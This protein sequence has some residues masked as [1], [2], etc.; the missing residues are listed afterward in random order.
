MGCHLDIHIPSGDSNRTHSLVAHSRYTGH[1]EITKEQLDDIVASGD[2]EALVGASE[3][4]WLECKGQPYQI[5]NDDARRE[6]AKDVSSFANASGGRLI[7]G[8][9][10]KSSSTHFGDEIA[11]VRSFAQ[12]LVN[13]SQY[14]AVL[15]AWVYPAIPGVTVIWVPTKN[16]PVDGV[17]VIT[18]PPQSTSSKPYLVTRTS[19]GT[20]YSETLLGYAERKGDKSKPLS[21]AELQA[22]LRAGLNYDA[23]VSSKF[24]A[25][26]TLIKS[27]A[28]ATPPP[29][30]KKIPEETVKQRIQ[31]AVSHGSIKNGRYIVIAA[32][33][34][35]E[36]Q[37]KTIF[38]SSAGSIRR[39]LEN[40][41]QLRSY[42]WDLTHHDQA[43]IMK[44]EAIRVTNGDSKVVD[45][46][47]D[48]TMIAAAPADGTFLA[49]G[50]DDSKQRL[51]PLALIEYI[52]SFLNFYS[53]V[54]KDFEMPPTTV[55]LRIELHHMYLENIN[56]TLGPY[57]LQSTSQQFAMH[58]QP[59]PADDG[60]FDLTVSAD[61]F[62]PLRL[63]FDVVRE[64]YL[65]FGIEEDKIPYFKMEDGV[66][67][68]DVDALSKV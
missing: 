49:W 33:P 14:A 29:P 15:D 52:Y 42:G 37:L 57:G 36:G 55:A 2:F 32:V 5:A 63:A 13:T 66:R 62:K 19:V 9:Q 3:T 11:K 43:K 59:A 1:V 17:V 24:E 39:Q 48:G 61:D 23:L 64:V 7:I 28:T 22:A 12:T 41:P 60:V 20:K 35:P 18:I 34:T 68:L 40:P 56:S 25:L 8:L 45:L 4:A 6:L 54:L 67:Q 58:E 53:L 44:R 16:D 26:E 65:W 31:T 38:S 47:R 10:T 46:Y 27:S 21:V 50:R 51:N 30:E